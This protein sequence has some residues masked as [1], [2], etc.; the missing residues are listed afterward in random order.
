[1]IAAGRSG[2]LFTPGS[3]ADLARQLAH[4]ASQPELMAQMS[5]AA[6]R[7]GE[8]LFDLTVNANKFLAVLAREVPALGLKPEVAVAPA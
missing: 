5:I 3:S 6:R 4:L 8:E 1:M 2:L 7:R